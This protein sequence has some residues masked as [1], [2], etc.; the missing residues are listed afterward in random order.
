MFWDIAVRRERILSPLK[1]INK[2]D[3]NIFETS[4]S[5]Y[6]FTWQRRSF[7]IISSYLFFPYSKILSVVSLSPTKMIWKMVIGRNSN[8]GKPLALS[9][10]VTG[11]SSQAGAARCWWS[12]LSLERNYLSFHIKGKHDIV[13][14][15]LLAKIIMSNPRPF[16]RWVFRWWTIPSLYPSI[17]PDALC[18]FAWVWRTSTEIFLLKYLNAYWLLRILREWAC[19]WLIGDFILHQHGFVWNE[20]KRE[21]SASSRLLPAYFLIERIGH[22]ANVNNR[23]C[24]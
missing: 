18:C 4:F 7:K 15:V 3:F 20:A 12:F 24:I 19:P 6:L 2:R 21:S 23:C 16:T 1:E 10:Y 13:F 17:L 9:L 11:C 5:A 8:V 14:A 22:L